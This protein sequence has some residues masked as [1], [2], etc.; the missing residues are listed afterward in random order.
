MTAWG[1]CGYLPDTELGVVY[2][3]VWHGEV[4]T[5]FGGVEGLDLTEEAS[6][7]AEEAAVALR[8]VGQRRHHQRVRGSHLPQALRQPHHP[9]HVV[10]VSGKERHVRPFPPPHRTLFS[11]PFRRRHE[12]SSAR[13]REREREER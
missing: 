10:P 6:L 5:V 2:D 3:V 1:R 7:R 12:K 11:L 13:G 8:H 9:H 4:G